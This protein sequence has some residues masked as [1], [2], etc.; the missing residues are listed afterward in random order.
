MKTWTVL[1]LLA[2]LA[3]TG[4]SQK[5]LLVKKPGS[6][7]YLM[8]REGD[9]IIFKT[10]KKSDEVFAI[11]TGITDTS[12]FFNRN[13]EMEFEKIYTV[14]K[15]R[16]WIGLFSRIF[17]YAGAGYVLL[18]G[19]NRTINKEFPVVQESTLWIGGSLIGFSFALLPLQKK[20]MK[21]GDPWIFV[22]MDFNETIRS[23]R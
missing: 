23:D 6:T 20:R 21:M 7:K 13:R 14:V 4:F 11:I 10:A 1:V 3:S 8:Y 2:M 12:I 16:H 9:N 22:V 18:D 17:R 5:V 15:E 19:V